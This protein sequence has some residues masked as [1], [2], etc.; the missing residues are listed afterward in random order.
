MDEKVLDE[1]GLY[2]KPLDE[3]WAHG[4]RDVT[5]VKWMQNG[6]WMNT[7]SYAAAM[8]DEGNYKNNDDIVEC[9]SAFIY[10]HSTENSHI[11][12]NANDKAYQ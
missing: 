6:K 9:S 4:C 1:N 3:N 10:Y 7:N 8:M 12:D 2:E 5:T 11:N